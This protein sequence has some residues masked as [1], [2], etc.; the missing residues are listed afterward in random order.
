MESDP[1][2]TAIDPHRS[3]TAPAPPATITLTVIPEGG[4][5]PEPIAIEP[6]A[7]GCC[8]MCLECLPGADAIHLEVAVGGARRLRAEIRAQAGER[9]IGRAHV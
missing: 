4:T 6:D 5:V 3:V 7:Q 2:S 8:R 9:E 1:L